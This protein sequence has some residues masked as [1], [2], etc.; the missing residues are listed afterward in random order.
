MEGEEEQPTGV[1]APTE[2]NSGAEQTD[3]AAPSVASAAQEECPP[4]SAAE[5]QI[6]TDDMVPISTENTEQPE[7]GVDEGAP[8]DEKAG[9][10][11]DEAKSA[12]E[13][14][15]TETEEIQR[16]NSNTPPRKRPSESVQDTD[17][18]AKVAVDDDKGGRPKGRISNRHRSLLNSAFSG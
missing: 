11:P 16:S 1:A 9:V 15:Q 2:V 8:K 4:N 13:P 7:A 18:S 17:R 5:P 10:E 14:A 3:A 6:A 12:P